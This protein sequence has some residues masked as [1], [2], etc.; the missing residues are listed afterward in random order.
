MADPFPFTV[1]DISGSIADEITE[2]EGAYVVPPAKGLGNQSVQRSGVLDA[3]GALVENAVTWRG[4]NAVTTT[5]AMPDADTVETLSGSWMFLG[6]LFG[7]FGHFLVES[8]CRHDWRTTGPSRPEDPP[9]P[10]VISDA[11][12]EASPSRV[13]TLPPSSAAPSITSATA[14][15]RPS[16]VVQLRMMP[17]T[18]PPATGM[19]RIRYHGRLAAKV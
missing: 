9:V 8:I 10:S 15:T 19:A 1:P 16:C 6:P 13:S 2:L 4:K 11:A 7:H 5:P 12:A 18:S 14:R 3:S 17:T